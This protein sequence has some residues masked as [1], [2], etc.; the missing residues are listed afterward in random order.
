MMK[1]L[2]IKK[3]NFL[4]ILLCLFLL[5]IDRLTKLIITKN[6]CNFIFCFKPTINE[7]AVFSLPIPM[8]VILV[9]SI[10]ILIATPILFFKI[11]EILPK[12]S[13]ILIFSGTLGNLIDRV[14]YG[15]VID[16]LTFSFWQSFPVFNFADVL[17]LAGVI[18][19][20]ITLF[21]KE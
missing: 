2:H 5:A 8:I 9:I 3:L 12:I 21:K 6:T 14:F 17:N 1:L 20:I 16:F 11:K 15:H 4:L 10:L 7:F 18:L 19:L 13:F